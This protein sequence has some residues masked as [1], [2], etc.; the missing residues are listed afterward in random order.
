M[1][2]TIKLGEQAVEVARRYAANHGTSLDDAV[3]ILVIQGS[4]ADREPEIAYPGTF[5]PF[6][7]DP[8]RPQYTSEQVYE[9]LDNEG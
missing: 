5:R 1:V 2:T 7:R 6:P 3:T 8:S 4:A 9:F